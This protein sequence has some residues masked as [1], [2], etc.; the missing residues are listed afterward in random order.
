MAASLAPDAVTP[1]LE[2]RFG[3]PYLYEPKTE[4]T[5]LLLLDS[6]LP[7]GA[8]AAAEHQTAGRGRLGRRWEE[9]AGTSV[10]CSVLLRP[11][12][13]RN[14]PELSL[15]A[16]LAVAHAVD[17]ATALQAQIKW[18]NDVLL[19]ERKIAGVLAEMRGDTVVVGIGINVNQTEEQLD[20][21][22]RLPAG[23]LRTATGQQHD[24]ARLLARLLGRLEGHY[25]TW[26]ACGLSALFDGLRK[27]DFL[28]GREV[29]V[30]GKAG[31]AAG[32]HPSG[33]L[34]VEVGGERRLIGSGE[35]LLTHDLR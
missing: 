2:G 23:S 26:T 30:D 3:D 35:V 11:P 27:R 31:T 4:S 20:A 12:A 28:R 16:A 22:A 7:E 8:V 34:E 32:I 33:R 9:P 10:L 29:T 14:P 6:G 25:G 1:L 21:V 24:R 19:E 5:Q 15:V 17:E 18:P 13:E